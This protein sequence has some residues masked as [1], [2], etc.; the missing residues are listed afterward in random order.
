MQRQEKT[1]D[2]GR[3]AEKE[4]GQRGVERRWVLTFGNGGPIE[5]L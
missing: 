5:C 2:E 1:L 3:K 4:R